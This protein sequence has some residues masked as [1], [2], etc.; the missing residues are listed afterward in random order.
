MR[1]VLRKG[2]DG[3]DGWRRGSPR[4]PAFEVGDDDVL[5][6]GLDAAEGV[7]DGFHLFLASGLEAERV[8]GEVRF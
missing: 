6:I 7:G 2:R 4:A 1:R 3:V 5:D 8:N